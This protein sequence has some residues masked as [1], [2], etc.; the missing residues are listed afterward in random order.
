MKWLH[1]HSTSIVHLLKPFIFLILN[2]YLWC[3]FQIWI[4]KMI[5]FL[6]WIL[7]ILHNFDNLIVWFIKWTMKWFRRWN[8]AL[9]YIQICINLSDTMSVLVTIFQICFIQFFALQL[10]LYLKIL[11]TNLRIFI[12]LFSNLFIHW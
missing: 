12:Y 7:F 3:I 4:L 10:I 5:F 8:L 11:F 1:S 2:K 9:K 6:K